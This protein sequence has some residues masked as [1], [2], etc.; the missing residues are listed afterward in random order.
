MNISF[1]EFVRKNV[2]GKEICKYYRRFTL[3]RIRL[4][5]VLL[6]LM[7]VELSLNL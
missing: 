7:I 4:M 2:T 5:N 3:R 1:Y 6:I